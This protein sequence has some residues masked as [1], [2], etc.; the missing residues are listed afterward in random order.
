MKPVI[1]AA[2]LGATAAV[3]AA[4][5]SYIDSTSNYLTAGNQ[6]LYNGAGF[7]F[8]PL[9]FSKNVSVGGITGSSFFG[10]YG[11]KVTATVGAKLKFQGNV[12]FSNTLTQ[13]SSG[14]V[15]T[16]AGNPFGPTSSAFILGTDFSS[17]THSTT[18]VGTGQV[19]AALNAT[20]FAGANISGKACFIECTSGTIANIGVGQPQPYKILGYHSATNSVTFLDK[21]YN[22]VLP[23]SFSSDTLPISATLDAIDVSGTAKGTT[24]TSFHTSQQ[25]AGAYVD[26]AQAV[27]DAFGLPQSVLSGSV[28]G[29]DYTTIAAKI[30]AGINAIYDVTTSLADRYVIYKLSTPVERLDP[31]TGKWNYYGTSISLKDGQIAELRPISQIASLSILPEV[32]TYT[33]SIATLTLNATLEDHVKLL[34]VSGYG[35]SAGPLYQQDGSIVLGTI[36]SYT[37]KASNLADTTLAP[38]TLDFANA[39]PKAAFAF[40]EASDAVPLDGTHSFVFVPDGIGG[41]SDTV[42]GEIML[43]TNFNT[44][45]CNADTIVACLFDR[46]FTP[47]AEQQRTTRDA[48]GAPVIT[49]AVDFAVAD[50][51]AALPDGAFGTQSTPESMRA[52]L[53]SLP[54]ANGY[55]LPADISDNSTPF[56]QTVPEP[57]SWAMMVA[58]F[59]LVGSFARR[60]RTTVAA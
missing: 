40:A 35:L 7:N 52:L 46:H 34:E 2:L 12:S 43:A 53:A 28:L 33:R 30:G 14:S 22:D 49:Y 59:G 9:D 41:T 15:Q 32:V 8:A 6:S 58:G 44:R 23:K 18:F 55:V 1:V 48:T 19:D 17:N 42:A 26:V 38:L 37:A 21:T 4:A 54:G 16:F 25:F 5:S 20:V 57:A 10:H 13:L 36:G 51:I 39:Q 31:N 47:I 11:A 3:P 50:R 56:M 60:R 45:G 29:F 27:V 24:S